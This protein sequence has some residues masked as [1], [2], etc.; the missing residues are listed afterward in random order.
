MFDRY[1]STALPLAT[2]SSSK[3]LLVFLAQ[4]VM[5]TEDVGDHTLKTENPGKI[6]MTPLAPT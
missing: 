1:Y 6:G 5:L 3:P 4:A 2:V